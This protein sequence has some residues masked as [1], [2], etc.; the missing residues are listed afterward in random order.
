MRIASAG[1]FRFNIW[2]C[3]KLKVLNIGIAYEAFKAS[4]A[5]IL[6]ILI[7][8]IYDYPLSALALM[9][10]AKFVAVALKAYLFLICVHIFC[11]FVVAF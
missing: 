2:W 1:F 3:A 9:V 10:N 8:L 7:K 11:S 5:H 4:I 6:V